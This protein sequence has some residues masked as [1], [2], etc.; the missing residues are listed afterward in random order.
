MI[1][2]IFSPQICHI[3]QKI[4][5]IPIVNAVISFEMFLP[6]GEEFFFFLGGVGFGGSLAPVCLMWCI[7]RECN[8]RSKAG[9]LTSSE[10]LPL[11]LSSLFLCN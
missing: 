7:W 3:W 5:C 11:L 9:G 1:S 2:D 4:D 6:D 10:S 8:W